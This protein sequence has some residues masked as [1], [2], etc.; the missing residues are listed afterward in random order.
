M[1][2]TPSWDVAHEECPCLG[3]S[4]EI[5]HSWPIDYPASVSSV[6]SMQL[7]QVWKCLYDRISLKSYIKVL[8]FF[9][10]CLWFLQ[11][12]SEV[13]CNFLIY[14]NLWHY[15]FSNVDNEAAGLIW[16]SCLCFLACFAFLKHRVLV[17]QYC[18]CSKLSLGVYVFSNFLEGKCFSV[19]N[20]AF[21]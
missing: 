18:F 11:R 1:R 16:R 17:T 9:L 2:S 19:E 4:W 21:S 8:F 15:F 3:S 10:Y 5:Q 7:I 14:S 13:Y 20:F 12:A 6:Y